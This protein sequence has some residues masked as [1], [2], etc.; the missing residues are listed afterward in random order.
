MNRPTSQDEWAALLVPSVLLTITFGV[1]GGLWGAIAG[2]IVGLTVLLVSRPIAFTL[3]HFVGIIFI[4]QPTIETILLLETGA[5][6]LLII[7]LLHRCESLWR[8]A[9][10][11]GT[12]SFAILV[13]ATATVTPPVG[14]LLTPAAVLVGLV[15][16]TV[17]LLRN[18]LTVSLRLSDGESIDE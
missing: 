12:V 3:A 1:L 2:G 9:I 10:A 17:Y 15:V 14:S 18:Y 6:S 13:I 7:D 11:L 5:F 4:S 16:L 8:P